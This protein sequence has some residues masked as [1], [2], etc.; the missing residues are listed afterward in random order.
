MKLAG[1]AVQEEGHRHAPLPLT[2]KRPVRPVGDHAVQARLAPRRKE[3]G[4]LD[5]AQRGRAQRFPS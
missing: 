5:A 2:R 3:I 1:L 4:V